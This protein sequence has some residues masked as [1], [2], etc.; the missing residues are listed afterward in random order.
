MKTFINITILSLTLIYLLEI[1]FFDK[2]IT[3]NL[4]LALCIT[5]IYKIFKNDR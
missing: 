3:A 5:I 4:I 2:R 1:M